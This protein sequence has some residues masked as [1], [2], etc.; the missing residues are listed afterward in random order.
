MPPGSCC[1]ASRTGKKRAESPGARR[2]IPRGPRSSS[3]SGEIPE[4]SFSA[5]HAT[6]RCFS[7]IRVC[8]FFFSFLLASRNLIDSANLYQ[9]KKVL[10]GF[11]FP[12]VLQIS[13]FPPNDKI[14]HLAPNEQWIC[15]SSFISPLL[16]LLSALCKLDRPR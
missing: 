16:S 9:K 8:F 7:C 11:L 14:L 6:Q 13:D 5:L 15:V 3:D 12:T 1:T 10:R 2:S 4:L